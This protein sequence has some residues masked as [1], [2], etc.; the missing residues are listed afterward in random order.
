MAELND[1]M[2]E[3]L[4]SAARRFDEIE[5]ELGNPSGSFDQARFT[6][7]SKERAT[8]EATVAAFMKTHPTIFDPS[9]TTTRSLFFDVPDYHSA[10]I[11]ASTTGT[12]VAK[13]KPGLHEIHQQKVQLNKPN[14][15][16]YGAALHK[17]VTAL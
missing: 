16:K 15:E 1:G 3:R 12:P 7:L 8:L 5:R 2:I 17:L 14:L 4:R 13:I 6:A 9:V 10:C 11:V